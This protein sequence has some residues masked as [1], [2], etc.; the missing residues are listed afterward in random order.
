MI[1]DLQNKVNQGLSPEVEAELTELRSTVSYIINKEIARD[2][3]GS[4]Q[5]IPE[6][7]QA[8]V[9]E[10]NTVRYMVSSLL[11]RK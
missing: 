1:I 4:S 3:I 5:L 9:S 7:W 10:V 2:G 11:R 6:G 8:R